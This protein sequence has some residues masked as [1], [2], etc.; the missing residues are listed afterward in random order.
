MNIHPIIVHFPI[1]LLVV[2]ALC[3]LVRFSF[4]TRQSYWFYVKAVLVIV[5]SLSAS[6]ALESGETAAEM[7]TER[8]P[9]VRVHSNFAEISSW[10]FGIIAFSY[11]IL[12]VHRVFPALFSEKLGAL[13]RVIMWLAGLVQRT[14]IIVTL[15]LFG[16]LFVTVTGGLGGA[17]VY[18]SNFDP[19]MRPILTYL[20]L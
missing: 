9:L 6:V 14:P 20:G 2:Y 17:I 5:G 15:S 11:L 7:L 12:W 4:V 19:F 18:G 10:I 8:N 3:E 1:A 16:L 13:G